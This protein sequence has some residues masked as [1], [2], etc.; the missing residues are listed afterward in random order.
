MIASGGIAIKNAFVMQIYADVLGKNISVTAC[1]Q[2]AALGS[3]IY[4][5]LAAGSEN[6]GY[7]DY[8]EAVQ[9]MSQPMMT[10][11]YPNAENTAIYA[12]LYKLYCVYGGKMG[13]DADQIMH[14]LR[15]I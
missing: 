2:A 5:T 11:Y 10:T 6:G 1:D 9:K 13:D 3:A 14:E 15:K 12:K 7:D 4:A 8:T